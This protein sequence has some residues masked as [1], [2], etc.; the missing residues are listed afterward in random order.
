MLRI[1]PLEFFL[2]GI[3]ES[4]IFILAAYAF[5]RKNIEIKRFISASLIL[6]I[7][8]YAVRFLPIHYGVNSILNLIIFIIITV[9]INKIDIIK[10]IQV[11]I[12]AMII[13]FICEGI[14]VFILQYV[15]HVDLNTVFSI[16]KLKVLYGS[17]SLLIFAAIVISY[18][19]IVIK[20]KELN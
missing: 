3:P 11:D 8:G 18:Y 1:T 2:R 12:I 15:F 19:K 9:N 20:R 10:A 4:F 6:A 14:D 5:T 17:P 16:P 13:Q 7:T